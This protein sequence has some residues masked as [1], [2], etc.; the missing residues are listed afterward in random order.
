ML[1]L[2]VGAWGT[3]EQSLYPG[4]TCSGDWQMPELCQLCVALNSH[5]RSCS[6]EP[7]TDRS[8]VHEGSLT[9]LDTWECLVLQYGLFTHSSSLERN[10]IPDVHNC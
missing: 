5:N 3:P 6:Q 8:V 1:G 10:L 7:A 2:C 9:F 4:G